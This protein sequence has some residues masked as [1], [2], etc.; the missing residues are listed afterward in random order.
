MLPFCLRA[1]VSMTVS[2]E[3]NL[4][5]GRARRPRLQPGSFPA[6]LDVNSQ[7]PDFDA[8]DQQGNPVRLADLRGRWVVLWWYPKASTSG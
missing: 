4:R 6:M 7:A 1:L 8:P 2:C 3:Q 5:R